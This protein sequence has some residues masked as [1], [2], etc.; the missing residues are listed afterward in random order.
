MQVRLFFLWEQ[1]SCQASWQSGDE[2]HIRE[3]RTLKHDDRLNY[4]TT[5]L[6]WLC[7]DANKDLQVASSDPLTHSL[8]VILLSAAPHDTLDNALLC[9]D[10]FCL[11]CS[12][13]C[14]IWMD[15]G[16]LYLTGGC[17]S[18]V[19]LCMS[20]IQLPWL[21]TGSHK[22]FCTPWLVMKIFKYIVV[23]VTTINTSVCIYLQVQGNTAC[24]VYNKKSCMWEGL[25]ELL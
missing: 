22:N 20:M 17:E 15:F 13:L 7:S 18:G 1:E 24:I 5:T 3:S 16:F 4:S 25:A 12:P 19:S 21:W 14:R 6:G 2:K 11:L 23:A 9:N 8:F 10:L